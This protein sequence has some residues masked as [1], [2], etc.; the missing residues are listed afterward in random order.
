MTYSTAENC[1]KRAT[2]SDFRRMK[3]VDV[4]HEKSSQI[5]SMYS[6][7]VTSGFEWF[8]ASRSVAVESYLTRLLKD[9]SERTRIER[10][11]KR[12]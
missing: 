10:E 4:K 6:L 2:V 12:E 7:F 5:S 3:Y 9:M 8:T 1:S 11:T